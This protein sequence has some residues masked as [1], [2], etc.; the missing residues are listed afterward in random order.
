MIRGVEGI[1]D[2]LHARLTTDLPAHIQ[3]INTE[4]AD[5]IVVPTP[6]V[7]DIY[8]FV[9]TPSMLT[10]FPTIGIGHGPDRL[11]DDTGFDATGVYD[12][13][14]VAYVQDSDQRV[15][16]KTVR[17]LKLAVQRCALEGRNLGTG[18]GTAWG[19]TYLAGDYGPTL[20]KNPSDN[21][22][23]SY[24]TSF[25]IAIRCKGDEI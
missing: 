1:V 19:V 21:A 16:A 6:D 2:A 17:R 7:R 15:L 18:T 20:S 14:I 8:E 4:R 13:H 5:G 3:A 12:L 10:T 25:A 23:G 24:M 22:P 11:E 9:P